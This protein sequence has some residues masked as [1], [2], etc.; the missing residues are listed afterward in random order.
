M[1]SLGGKYVV[2]RLVRA[3]ALSL[4]IAA[5]KREVG[6]PLIIKV[7]RPELSKDEG[8]VNRFLQVARQASLVESDHVVRI[9]EF[10][11]TTEQGPPYCVMERLAGGTF[12]DLLILH[13]P[14]PLDLAL[15]YAIQACRGLSAAHRRGLIHGDLRP[16]K[17][18]RTYRDDGSARIRIVDFGLA[19]S[20]GLQ[21][22]AFGSTIAAG[23][24]A[25]PEYRAPEQL[26]GIRS[27]E[28]PTDAWA[29]GLVLYQLLTG[30]HP[31]A[32]AATHMDFA[33]AV[34][35][36]PGSIR[37]THPD[38]PAELDGILRRC[39]QRDPGDRPTDLIQVAQK[40]EEIVA[41]LPRSSER[42]TRPA[43]ARA[44]DASPAPGGSAPRQG[45]VGGA[46]PAFAR[47]FLGAAMGSHR[48][49][50][51]SSYSIV[52]RDREDA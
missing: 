3:G 49:T 11:R 13:G 2:E 38:A 14:P 50:G 20:L 30:R 9:L 41:R 28:T 25:T 43:P 45:G 32:E 22:Q 8:N 12:R 17:L 37:N 18:Y 48:T 15:Q 24:A 31:F 27:I 5:E 35:G 4:V 29:L 23:G 21:S 26:A 42:Q 10:G 39:L 46:P 34:E 40:L 36:G 1:E 19:Q 44:Q 52:G 47:R 7:L 16:G 51:G 33:R 6:T